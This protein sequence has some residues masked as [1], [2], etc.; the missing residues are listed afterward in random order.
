MK[1]YSALIFISALISLLCFISFAHGGRTDSNGGHYD[2]NTGE[3][4]YHHGYSAHDHYDMDGDGDKDCPY[5]FD[6]KTNHNSNSGNSN[7]GNSNNSSN[8]S[9]QDRLDDLFN[10]TSKSDS[11]ES[12]TDKKQLSFWDIVSIIFEIVG[13]S[14]LFSMFLI[15]FG[16]MVFSFIVE[17]VIMVNIRESTLKR[18]WIVL[19]ITGFV[20]AVTLAT[21]VV[22]NGNG[23]I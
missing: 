15:Y 16:Y 1:K 3:Y 13:L 6:D 12:I 23:I 20:C 21:L 17:V 22:L 14:I 10:D 8:S 2:R 11:N 9:S 5:N 19:L 4:H 18:V 7:S